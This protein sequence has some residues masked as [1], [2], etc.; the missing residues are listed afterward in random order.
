MLHCAWSRHNLRA[1]YSRLVTYIMSGTRL[2]HLFLFQQIPI[3][4]SFFIFFNFLFLGGRD[5]SI[6]CEGWMCTQFRLWSVLKQV[7]N[8]CHLW[9][10]L[11]K[12]IQ[13]GFPSLTQKPKV[14]LGRNIIDK[15]FVL[16]SF[17]GKLDTVETSEQQTLCWNLVIHIFSPYLC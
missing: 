1:C 8:C 3:S 15:G 16:T 4:F 7:F 6:G 9:Q 2:L 10:V 11:F 13:F 14:S 17:E 12:V 5:A